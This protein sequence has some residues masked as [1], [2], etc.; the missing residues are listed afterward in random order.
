M[1]RERR[2]LEFDCEIEL[3]ISSLCDGEKNGGKLWR[4]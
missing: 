3:R 2:P 1:Q 4:Q